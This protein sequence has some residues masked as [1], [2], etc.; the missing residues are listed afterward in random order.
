M[1]SECVKLNPNNKNYLVKTIGPKLQYVIYS[2]TTHVIANLTWLANITILDVSIYHLE[3]SLT[4]ICFHR[5]STGLTKRKL[6]MQYT[7]S[8]DVYA[9]EA[10]KPSLHIIALTDGPGAYVVIIQ[11][12]SLNSC[13]LFLFILVTH[14]K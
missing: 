7:I 5:W 12:N 14:M 4:A 13:D 1:F 6:P 10:Q 9:K 3:Q 8:V 11:V 2:F